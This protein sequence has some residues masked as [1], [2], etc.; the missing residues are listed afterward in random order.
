MKIDFSEL[1]EIPNSHFKGGE[2]IFYARMF[3][4]DNVKIM[5]G[6]LAPG[7]SIGLHTH[8]GNSEIVYILQGEGKM[9]C[10]SVHENLSAGGL[11]LLPGGAVPY[12]GK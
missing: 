12:A 8:E 10:E 6:R 1:P 2:G 5:R 7:A 11:Q 4:D 9:M 3:N